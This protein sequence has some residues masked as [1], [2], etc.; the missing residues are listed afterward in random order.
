[1]AHA[2]EEDDDWKGFDRTSE[3]E[4]TEQDAVRQTLTTHPSAH[5]NTFTL[6]H[7]PPYTYT[8][9]PAPTYFKIQPEDEEGYG[10]LAEVRVFI[11][12]L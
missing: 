8:H 10:E 11:F 9:T 6:F 12:H 5:T 4:N 2:G 1:M 3:D 7:I